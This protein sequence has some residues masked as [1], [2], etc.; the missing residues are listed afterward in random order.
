MGASRGLRR[1]L[2]PSASSLA[3]ARYKKASSLLALRSIRR[4]PCG[5]CLGLVRERPGDVRA[6]GLPIYV[7][8][9]NEQICLR[10]QIGRAHV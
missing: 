1:Q 2:A 9:V 10:Q 6:C 8:N 7:I 4:R 3:D 5:Y